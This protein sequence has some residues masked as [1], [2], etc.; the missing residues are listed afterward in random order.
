LT[1]ADRQAL[2]DAI[3]NRPNLMP[4]Y[5]VN[6]FPEFVPPFVNPA[7][8]LTRDG[9]AA[10]LRTVVASSRELQYDLVDRKGK[11][12]AR[13][14]IPRNERIVAFGVKSV[15]VAWKDADDIERLRRHPWP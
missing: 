15:Y 10:V 7:L 13:F 1:A 14:A 4:P 3:P 2:I 8:V 9:R 5:D 12:V 11:L 6:K